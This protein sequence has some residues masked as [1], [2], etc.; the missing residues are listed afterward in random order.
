MIL[1]IIVIIIIVIIILTMIFKSYQWVFQ[2]VTEFHWAHSLVF[3][4]LCAS[5]S[6][7]LYHKAASVLNFL[8]D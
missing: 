6:L 4:R 1:V 5:H 8:Q 3:K 2:N 7:I